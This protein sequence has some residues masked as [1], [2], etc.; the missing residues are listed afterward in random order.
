MEIDQ[1]T[2]KNLIYVVL[3]AIIVYFILKNLPGIA[4]ILGAFIGMVS[5]FILGGAIAFILNVPMKAIEEKWFAKWKRGAKLKRPLAYVITL[6]L[7]ITILLVVLFVV[8][9]EM[10][11]TINML[12]EQVPKAFEEVKQYVMGLEAYLPQMQSILDSLN[13]NWEKMAQDMIAFLQNAASGVFSSTVGIVGGII[14]GVT[15][16][17]IGF[18]FSIYILFQKENLSRQVKKLLYALLPLKAA[19]KAVY[20]GKLSYTTFSNFLSG[21]CVEAVILGLMFFVAMS[22]FRMPYAVLIGMLIALLALIPIFG[23]FIGLGLGFFLIVMVNPMQAFAFVILFL[24]LQQIEGNLIYPHV[25]GGTVGLPSI[26]VLFAVTIGGKLMG[27]TGMLLFIPVC[28]VCY[29]L[30][31]DYAA[32]RVQKRKVPE[33]RWK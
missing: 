13:L 1:R 26:W 9:P 33:S 6:L 21:Q 17:F 19:D 32:L 5:P 31:K 11:R 27:I 20:I 30:L 14:N 23:A 4:G 10:A 29:A 8:I 3:T 12:V 7:L 18:I 28:S 2:K 16:F 22:I 24:V 15:S 25:V